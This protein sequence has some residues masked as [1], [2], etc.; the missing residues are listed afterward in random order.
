MIEI[1]IIC[2]ALGSITTGLLYFTCK[3]DTPDTTE[4]EDVR[5]YDKEVEDIKRQIKELKQLKSYG[6]VL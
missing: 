4:E 1:T 2:I 5:E 3:H 6:G